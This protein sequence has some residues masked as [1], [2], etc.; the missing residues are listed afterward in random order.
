LVNVVIGLWILT[1]TTGV[2]G[3]WP[4]AWRVGAAVLLGVGALL[5][6][7]SAVVDLALHRRP[8]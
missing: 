6:A 1:T 3:A 8:V 5:F 4:I 7:I 2:D